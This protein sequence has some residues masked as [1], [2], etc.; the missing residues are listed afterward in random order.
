MPFAITAAA[1]ASRVG[2]LLAPLSK[3]CSTT[4]LRA[5]SELNWF[6]V[7]PIKDDSPR[8]VSSANF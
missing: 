5:L 2:A 8:A 7:Q 4:R 3:D 1:Q 6:I